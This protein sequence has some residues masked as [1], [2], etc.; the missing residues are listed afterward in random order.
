[1]RSEKSALFLFLLCERYR[2]LVGWETTLAPEPFSVFS[3]PGSLIFLSFVFPKEQQ[4]ERNPDD[5]WGF[6]LKNPVPLFGGFHFW[7]LYCSM[8]LHQ[9]NRTSSC[10]SPV[11]IPRRKSNLR[12]KRGGKGRKKK[13]IPSCSFITRE[14]SL[15]FGIAMKKTKFGVS[16]SIGSPLSRRISLPEGRFS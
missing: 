3:F 9:S 15:V 2:D 12:A 1:L 8:L 4:N 11:G 13:T 14:N 6:F 7:S 16:L 10:L 5:F